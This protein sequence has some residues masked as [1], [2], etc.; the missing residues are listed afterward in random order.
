MVNYYSWFSAGNMVTCFALL[1]TNC[2]PIS[3]GMCPTS[4]RRFFS[5]HVGSNVHLHLSFPVLM[6]FIIGRS[7]GVIESQ[8]F[9]LQSCLLVRSCFFLTSIC[10]SF[11]HGWHSS[12][13]ILSIFWQHTH[14]TLST[15]RRVSQVKRLNF[16]EHQ[17]TQSFLQNAQ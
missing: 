14:H 9:L 13:C 7:T 12:A 5:A 16:T 8:V 17:C 15:T 10:S 4:V 3:P 2:A 6:W 1:Y 11:I